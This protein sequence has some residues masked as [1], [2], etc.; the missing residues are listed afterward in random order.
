M[1][2]CGDN[3]NPVPPTVQYHCWSVLHHRKLEAKDRSHWWAEGSGREQAS[4]GVL[5]YTKYMLDAEGLCTSQDRAQV[6]RVVYLFKYQSWA[7]SKSNWG[8][9]GDLRHCQSIRLFR[10]MKLPQQL[11]GENLH[12]HRAHSFSAPFGVRWVMHLRVHG[13]ILQLRWPFLCVSYCPSFLVLLLFF[14]L[15]LTQWTN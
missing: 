6:E 9:A 2:W 13:C 7:L 14:L 11:L 3:V 4:G 10:W 5:D 12:R 8:K 1:W 15:N